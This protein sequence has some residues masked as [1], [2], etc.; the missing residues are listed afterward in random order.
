M[1]L[2]G[3]RTGVLLSVKV[4]T[5]FTLLGSDVKQWSFVRTLN[6]LSVLD[7]GC[8]FRTLSSLLVHVFINLFRLATGT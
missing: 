2:L 6:T 7:K 5:F 1:G 4:L 3:A 8:L